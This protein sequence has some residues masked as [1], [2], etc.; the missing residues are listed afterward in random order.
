MEKEW[1]EF[2][3]D[4]TDS[5][6]DLGH[7]GV[8]EED[9]NDDVVEIK[10]FV[11]I[12][13]SL[14]KDDLCTMP[15]GGFD[16]PAQRSAKRKRK[17]HYKGIRQRPWGKW[18][19]EIRDPIKGVRVWLGTFNSAE[20]AARAYDV[21]A[22][23]IRGKKAKLNF[24]EDRTFAQK[25]RA[26]PTAPEV[27]KPRTSREHIFVPAVNNLGNRSSFV[28]PSASF[29]S[30]HPVVQLDHVSMSSV[31]PVE[32]RVTN[33]YSDRGTNSFG[34]SDLGWNYHTKAP[35]ISSTT[36]ISTIVEGDGSLHVKNNTNNLMVP[37]VMENN[38]ANF[39][40]WM[41]YL[42]DNSVDEMIDS[43]LNFDVPQDSI[44]NISKGTK[45][46]ISGQRE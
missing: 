20:E 33:M 2:L 11:S 26:P 36:R 25:S 39:E 29:A 32:A 27:P 38:A 15:T 43:L 3:V 44:G 5:D 41:R 42:M 21:A 24:P 30:K 23:R 37:H 14:S 6:L 34:C 9:Y 18:V 19:A 1:E 22:R 16:S 40:P 12:S 28:Y 45:P 7:D 8:V 31:A 35:H 10:P 17:T 4:S 46:S 13:R